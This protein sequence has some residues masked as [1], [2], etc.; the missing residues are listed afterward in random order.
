MAS[1]PST[2]ALGITQKDTTFTK[3]F[4]GG[5]P[6]HTTDQSLREYFDKF[7]DIDEAVVITDRQT[8]K[9]RGYGFE[10]RCVLRGK[11][12]GNDGGW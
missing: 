11:V 12:D 4:V 10:G 5:L 2:P 3:I 1:T 9:S 7:G 6:Y 8:G